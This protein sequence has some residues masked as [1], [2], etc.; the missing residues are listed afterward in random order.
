[1]AL[2]STDGD[3]PIRRVVGAGALIIAHEAHS[4]LA[5]PNV[6]GLS[7]AVGGADLRRCRLPTADLIL[8]SG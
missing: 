8:R 5:C 1:M 3:W 7:A 4:Q 2:A 6:A